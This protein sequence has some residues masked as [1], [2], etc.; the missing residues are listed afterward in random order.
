M[1][2]TEDGGQGRR[3]TGR[4]TEPGKRGHG[5]TAGG[6]LGTVG[7][8]DTE[9]VGTRVALRIGWGEDGLGLW[10]SAGRHGGVGMEAVG[11]A[12]FGWGNSGDTW[13]RVMEE[14]WGGGYVGRRRKDGSGLVLELEQV[15]AMQPEG[16][17]L[18]VEDRGSL[19]ER[20]RWVGG[21]GVRR[22]EEVW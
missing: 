8:G 4:C 10:D 16:M 19:R 18:Q 14:Y 3:G 2:R 6:A 22:L 17:G 7:T 1:R 11:S 5:N 12:S 15:S 20:Y 9:G 13:N 21:G